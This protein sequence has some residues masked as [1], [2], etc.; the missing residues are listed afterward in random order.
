MGRLGLNTLLIRNLVSYDQRTCIHGNRQ[1]RFGALSGHIVQ[2]I[3]LQASWLVS[4]LHLL[5]F[6]VEC[7]DSRSGMARVNFDAMQDE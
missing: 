1:R 5:A 4:R 7:S 2:V 3:R 6:A